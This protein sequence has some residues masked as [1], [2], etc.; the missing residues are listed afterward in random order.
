AAL[1][2]GG[3]GLV[4]GELV[5]GPLL[6]GRLTALTGDLALF[7]DVHR[8][9]TAIAGVG[10]RLHPSL[11]SKDTARPFGRSRAD[12]RSAGQTCLYPRTR[13]AQ[14]PCPGAWPTA[15]QRAAVLRRGPLQHRYQRAAPRWEQ[16]DRPV[17]VPGRCRP[18]IHVKRNGSST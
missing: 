16:I 6:V 14:A 2:A 3:A 1:A 5:R 11:R 4:G 8:C 17:T 12:F 13:A 7:F 10:L 9:K 18:H 15:A